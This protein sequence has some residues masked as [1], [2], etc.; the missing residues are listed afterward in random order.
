MDAGPAD[1]GSG[2]CAVSWA[3]QIF[4]STTATGA[5]KCAEATSCH[6]G[7]QGPKMTS[8]PSA[9]YKT[10]STYV[11]QNAP[12]ALPYVLPGNT[13]PTKSGLVCNVSG[14]NC[15]PQMPLAG[16]V[17]GTAALTPQEITMVTTWVACGAPNN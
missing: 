9:T 3:T 17:T 13:D 8:D 5:W 15:G 16:V 14:S 12:Q 11:M 7:L 10:L 2:A 4:P 6:G 1:A